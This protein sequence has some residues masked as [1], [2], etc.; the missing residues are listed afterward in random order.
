MQAFA[1][2]L[3]YLVGPENTARFYLLAPLLVLAIALELM[4]IGIIPMLLGTILGSDVYTLSRFD[5]PERTLLTVGSLVVIAVFLLK[6]LSMI[7]FSYLQLDL[8][9]RVRCSISSRLYRR[10]LS[11]SLEASQQQHSAERIRAIVHDIEGL[12]GRVL[13]PAMTIVQSCFS[14]LAIVVFVIFFLPA[15]VLPVCLLLLLFGYGIYRLSSS[16]MK[17]FGDLSQ[18]HRQ[19]SIKNITEGLE[20]IVVL[21]TLGVTAHFADRFDRE[22]SEY[23]RYSLYHMLTNHAVPQILEFVAVTLIVALLYVYLALNYSPADALPLL[24]LVVFSLVR[25][26]TALFATLGAVNSIH[27]GTPILKSLHLEL[28][29]NI[30]AEPREFK[31]LSALT[32]ED[33][34]YTHPGKTT[35]TLHKLNFS[36]KSGETIAIV[37]PSGS[38]KTSFLHLLTGIT[39]PSTGR[40][41]LNE[42]L[43]SEPFRLN[44]G[45]VPQTVLLLNM[46]IRENITLGV[47]PEE[48]DEDKLAKVISISGLDRFL[49]EKP[50]GAD[51][52]IGERGSTLSGGKRQRLGIAR[53]LYQDAEVLVLDEATASLDPDTEE[54]VLQQLSVNF[55]GTIL[56]TSHRTNPLKYCDRIVTIDSGMIRSVYDNTA[57]K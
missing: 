1:K 42:E 50:E 41:L 35:P 7:W 46:S 25:L 32:L 49:A 11:K 3:L 20:N 12:L 33:V 27:F 23:S 28:T 14:V 40:I 21:K 26:R 56:M 43:V 18:A 36:M 34:T 51:F 10:Y 31:G 5:S 54:E 17:K 39:A 4:S 48:V 22:V 29:D 45:Y 15:R 6:N 16:R 37:G 38:G 24:T 9:R 44:M 30:P 57:E 19:E 53:A 52:L 47:P 55:P 13:L 2:K 8:I